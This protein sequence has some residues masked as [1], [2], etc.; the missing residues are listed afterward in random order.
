[1][2]Q[3]S[4]LR[5]GA[6]AIG[7][8]MNINATSAT[9]S[10]T[11]AITVPSNTAIEAS[12]VCYP[13]PSHIVT[14][15]RTSFLAYYLSSRPDIGL[16][17]YLTH[18]FQHG[19]DLMFVGPITSTSPRNL[20]SIDEFHEAVTHALHSELLLG[21][22]SG[23]FRSP[24]FPRCHCSPLGAVLKPSGKIRS[25]SLPTQRH[26]SERVHLGEVLF[27]SLFSF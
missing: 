20:R 2:P 12:L 15:I 27:S 1:M 7:A 19:F 21:H 14:P 8:L 25:R 10:T 6:P 4:H 17:T 23:L 22:I 26:F 18:G 9:A 16:V 13:L 3:G 11:A 5:E 24:P